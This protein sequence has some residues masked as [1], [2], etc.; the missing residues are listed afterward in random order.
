ML[1]NRRRIS[2]KPVDLVRRF[3]QHDP[4]ALVDMYDLYWRLVYFLIERIV[5]DPEVAGDLVQESFLRAWDRSEE[6]VGND[7]RALGSWLM[8]IARNRSLEYL[9]QLKGSD[10]AF[11]AQPEVS[12]E[13]AALIAEAFHDLSQKQRQVMEL[14][15]YEGLSK[16][17]LGEPAE[18]SSKGGFE[19]A[20]SW[21]RG[22]NDEA[23]LNAVES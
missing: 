16:K 10:A 11:S 19:A 12:P 20:M 21:L 2:D 6:L 3:R 8:V 15:Y 22:D 13:S 7:D 17:S 9:G 1:K 5:R 14:A 18:V 4:S 23:A